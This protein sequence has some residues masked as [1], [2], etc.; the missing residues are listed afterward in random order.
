MRGAKETFRCLSYQ[1]VDSALD[2]IFAFAVVIVSVL[3][4]GEAEVWM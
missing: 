1:L 4:V 3:S 2:V